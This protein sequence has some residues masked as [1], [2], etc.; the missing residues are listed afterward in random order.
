[1]WGKVMIP[2]TAGFAKVKLGQSV[3]ASGLCTW[4]MHRTTHGFLQRKNWVKKK[5]KKENGLWKK[6]KKM[7]CGK[8]NGLWK[9]ENGLCTLD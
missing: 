8:K 9:K 5:W 3:V 2:L 7:D 1:M 4:L 6:K